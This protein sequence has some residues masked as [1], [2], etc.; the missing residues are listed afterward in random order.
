MLR[1]PAVAGYALFFAGQL[2]ALLYQYNRSLVLTPAE[3]QK[4]T[5]KQCLF[6]QNFSIKSMLFRRPVNGRKLN[7]Q[8]SCKLRPNFPLKKISQRTM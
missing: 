8:R 4:C 6:L 5:N 7:S 2:P 3:T 1:R